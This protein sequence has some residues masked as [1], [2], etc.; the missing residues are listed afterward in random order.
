MFKKFHR[1]FNGHKT[2]HVQQHQY[3]GEEMLKQLG[4]QPGAPV[5]VF[6]GGNARM[7]SDDAVR[8]ER[9][10]HD[11]VARAAVELGAI[12]IDGGTDSGI[13]GMLNAALGERHP[14]GVYIGVAPRPLTHL[15][16]QP[17]RNL[18]PLGDAHTH[19]ILVESENWGDELAPMYALI[20][21]LAEGAPSVGILV[22]GGKGTEDEIGGN[23]GENHRAMVIDAGARPGDKIGL[24]LRSPGTVADIDVD[25]LAKDRDFKTVDV[26][27]NPDKLVKRIKESLKG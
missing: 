7:N 16:N 8:L 4:I 17:N 22:I 21:A 14:H 18:E 13:L 15:P 11:G 19:F 12:V 5:I 2:I 24:R 9:A 3:S 1:T 20:N 26:D 23:A 25:K 6:R 27:L 10:I